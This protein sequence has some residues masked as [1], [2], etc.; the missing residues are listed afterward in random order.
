MSVRRELFDGTDAGEEL[1]LLHGLG[2]SGRKALK[3]LAGGGSIH[4]W[5]QGREGKI[6]LFRCEVFLPPY[7]H[8]RDYF[9]CAAS[10]ELRSPAMNC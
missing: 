5:A 7:G 2:V 10:H 9:F 3:A 8:V 4:A 1:G 6:R